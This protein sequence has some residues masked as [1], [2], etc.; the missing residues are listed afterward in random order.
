MTHPNEEPV[1]ISGYTLRLAE[2][3]RKARAAYCAV[4]AMT[5]APGVL[6]EARQAL[7]LTAEAVAWS[8]LDDI[9]K[10]EGQR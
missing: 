10:A 1:Q 2:K 4:D 5:A 7:Q 9:D 6:D 8:V 3:H